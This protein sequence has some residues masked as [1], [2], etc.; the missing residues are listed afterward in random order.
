[1]KRAYRTVEVATETGGFAVAL[2]GKRLNTPKKRPL[3]LPTRGLAE[4]IAGEWAAQGDTIRP[5]TM[6]L[7]QIAATALDEVAD[8]RLEM[9]GEIAAY[10]HT[11]LLCYRAEGPPE[12]ARRQAESWQPLLDW[13]THRFDASLAVTH[14]VAPRPQPAQAVAALRAAV[15]RLSDLELAALALA[16][17]ACGSVVLGLALIEGSLDAEAATRASLLDELYQ[18][19]LWGEDEE[20]ASRRA[21]IGRDTVAAAELVRLLRE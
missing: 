10:A 2:D 6:P 14:G 11:D 4:A 19:E 15:E 20:A 21:A 12:L 5:W 8:R 13:A 1:M 9:V 7:T 17:A 18:A 16:V 3:L